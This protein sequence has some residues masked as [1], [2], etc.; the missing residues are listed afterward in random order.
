MGDDTYGPFWAENNTQGAP[1]QEYPYLRTHTREQ[2][3]QL[4]N[5]RGGSGSIQAPGLQVLLL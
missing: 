5:E 2:T 1:A 4:E 3:P